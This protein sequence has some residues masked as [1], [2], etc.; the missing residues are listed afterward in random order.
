M[1]NKLDETLGHANRLVA[2]LNSAYGGDSRFSREIDR[3]LPQL[4]E[5][6]RSFRALADL[7]S[8]HPEALIKGRTNTGKE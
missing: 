5:M 4:N 1:A 3:L 7:L 6:T 2:S 8:R